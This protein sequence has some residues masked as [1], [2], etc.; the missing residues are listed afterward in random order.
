MEGTAL[1]F[2]ALIAG[3]LTFFAP[4]TFPLLPAYL[5]FISGVSSQELANANTAQKSRRRIL[6]NGMFYVLGFSLVFIAL[7]VLSG[8]AGSVLA[9][10]RLWLTRIGGAFV[11]LSGF[12]M[13]GALQ[14]PFL[15]R[16]FKIRTPHFLIPGKSLNSFFLGATFALGWTPCVGPI[17]GSILLA[18]ST[19]QTA[20]QGA[21]LLAVFSLGLAI[22]FLLVAASGD[23]FVKYTARFSAFFSIIGGLF[24]I[25]LGLLLFTGKMTLLIAYGYRLFRF[26]NYEKL[27]EYL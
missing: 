18:A 5:A 7:G 24:L 26:I 21:L 23:V 2:P 22:P 19:S 6:A 13:L 12:F 11:M 1:I 25:V 27:L 15:A 20:G 9:P 10:Y 3:F 16:D 4:C 8:V 14:I 17:L